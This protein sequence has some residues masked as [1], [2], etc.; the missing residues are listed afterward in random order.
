MWT[1][2]FRLGGFILMLIGVAMILRP[3]SVLADVIPFLGNI[4]GAGTGILSFLIAAPFAFLTVAVAWLRYRPVIGISL[5][6][7]AAV[8]TGLIFIVSKRGRTSSVSSPAGGKP[9]KGRAKKGLVSNNINQGSSAHPTPSNPDG[10]AVSNIENFPQSAKVETIQKNAADMI[11]KGQ[12]YFRTGQYDKAVMQ[13]SR[14]IKSEGNRKLAL[15]NRGVALFKLNKRDAAL[16]DFKYAAKLGHEK[17]K[18]IL[19]QI[20]PNAA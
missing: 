20:N 6:I 18:A 10:I 3:L 16:K 5:L 7:L 2:I 9:T 11:K 13:F 12:N 19:N 1:W 8:A 14:V 17:A 4:V 15:Y